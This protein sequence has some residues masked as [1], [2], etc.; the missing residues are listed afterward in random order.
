MQA[1][2]FLKRLFRD[3]DINEKVCL[4]LNFSFL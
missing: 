3:E 1:D 4:L 2:T